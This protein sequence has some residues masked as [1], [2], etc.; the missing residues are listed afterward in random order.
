MRVLFGDALLVQPRLIW[1]APPLQKQLSMEPPSKA[2]GTVDTTEGVPGAHAQLERK[3]AAVQAPFSNGDEEGQ[4]GAGI[5]RYFGWQ[6]ENEEKGAPREAIGAHQQQPAAP[7]KIPG[8]PQKAN[9][10]HHDQVGVASVTGLPAVQSRGHATCRS[11][12]SETESLQQGMSRVSS[13]QKQGGG[14]DR[15]AQGRGDGGSAA[16]G[17]AGVEVGDVEE[18]DTPAASRVLEAEVYYGA[19]A[20]EGAKK[21]GRRDRG[22]STNKPWWMA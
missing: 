19:D 14:S 16:A 17:K 18:E 1:A 21:R 10:K 6:G 20:S 11:G 9:P 5:A 2:D 8:Q 7:C 12:D 3:R 15:A 4:V 13:K 22:S